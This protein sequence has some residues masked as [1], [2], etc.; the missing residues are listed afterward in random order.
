MCGKGKSTKIIFNTKIYN[1]GI[2]YCTPNTIS[3]ENI[4]QSVSSA[5]Q[6]KAIINANE[7]R[8]VKIDNEL[9][10][11]S[12]NGILGVMDA[13]ALDAIKNGSNKYIDFNLVKHN[14]GMLYFLIC[15]RD[16]DFSTIKIN[17][18]YQSETP[19]VLN[20][21]HKHYII[22]HKAWEYD[23]DNLITLCNDCHTKVHQTIGAPV[24]SDE[25]GYFKEIKLTPCYKCNGSGYFPEYKHVENGICFRCR[26]TRFEELRQINNSY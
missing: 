11:I 12:N 24:Y 6:F 7:I 14:S 10:A 18:P 1:I 3:S 2:N 19:I 20:V 15:K 5:N 16:I 22:Q 8:I 26:G 17:L 23:E 21:H 4:I 13:N 9:V 25:N